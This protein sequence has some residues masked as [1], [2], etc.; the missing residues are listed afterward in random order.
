MSSRDFDYYTESLDILD[1]IVGEDRNV[2]Q[3]LYL[4]IETSPHDVRFLHSS[5]A[6]QL[7]GQMMNWSKER[8]ADAIPRHRD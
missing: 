5:G 7:L 6:N 4:D 2:A 3:L 8:D 1:E